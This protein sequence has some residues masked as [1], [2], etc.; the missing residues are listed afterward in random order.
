LKYLNPWLR[1][2]Y[3]TPK[4]KIYTIKIP[5]EGMRSNGQSGILTEKTEMQ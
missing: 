3:L 2:P 5:V 1:K 4:N